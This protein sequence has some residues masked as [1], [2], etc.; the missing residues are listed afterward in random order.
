MMEFLDQCL[1]INLLND[2]K[3]REY[4]KTFSNLQLKHLKSKNINVWNYINNRYSDSESFNESLYRIINNIENRPV[5][6]V[7]GNK[8]KYQ[9]LRIGF[10]HTCSKDC[11]SI[12]RHNIAIKY[13]QINRPDVK[14]KIKQ[15]LFEKYGSYTTFGSKIIKEKIKNINFKK[16]GSESPFGSK[17]I[18]EKCKETKLEKYGD[19]YYNNKEKCKKTKLERHGDEKYNNTEKRIKTCQEKFDGNAPICS[20]E[21]YNKIKETNILKYGYPYLMQNDDLKNK[22]HETNKI[23][24][25]VPYAWNN[26][27]QKKTMIEKYGIPYA[28]NLPSQKETMIKKYGVPYAMQSDELKRKQHLSTK[29]N[30]HCNTSK[31]EEYAYK[32]LINKFGINNIIRQYNSKLYPFNCDFY[33]KSLDIYI[34]IQGSQFHHFHPFN[35]NNIDDINELNRLKQ[36]V[37]PQYKAII[38]VWTIHDP[39]K[40]N[41]AKQNNLNFYEF[42]NSND[43]DKW[44]NN[45][46]ESK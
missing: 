9:G 32:S 25:G 21:I 30:G 18:Q 10:K 22:A 44:I 28:F 46:G 34:E 19:E 20:N 24:Y 29:N 4:L 36:K 2:D 27:K 15:T 35:E 8:V 12:N 26:E 33:I 14:E 39:Y 3:I 6:D 11:E 38:D 1:D 37:N 43:F 42:Y 16:Y 40:R 45:Y 41:I 31:F 17:E 23:K 13:S 5:C 7:C